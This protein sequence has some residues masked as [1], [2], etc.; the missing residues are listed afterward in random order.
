MPDR[1]DRRFQLILIKPSHY[2]A[3]GY[4]IQW[5]K[6]GM[7]SNSLAS[8]YALAQDAKDN[9]VLGPD[10]AIDIT[11]VDETNKAIHVD[12]LIA[13]LDEHDGFGL[14]G[15][16]GVQSNEYFRALDIARQFRNAGLPV[17]IG[18]FHVSGCIAMFPDILP[19]LQKALDM[20]ITLFAGEGEGR[21][22]DLLR[23]VAG[24][25]M[26]PV[27]NYMSD[28]PDLRGS[29]HPFLPKSFH[30]NVIGK[31]TS[32]DAGRGCPYQC[33]F[34]TIINVQGRVSRQRS[35]DDVEAIIRANWA[36]NVDRFFITDD[37]FARNKDWEPIFDRIIELRE[38]DGMDVR[39]MIQVDT[40][41]HKI[42]NF[43]EKAKRAGVTRVFIGLENINPENLI[44]AQKRQNKITD[45]R[46]MLLGWKKVGI[47]V[48]AGYILGFPADTEESIRRDIEIIKKELPIDALEFFCLTPLPGS[49]D[50]KAMVERGEWMD[51]D[52]N[53]Y[54]LEHVVSHH[55][56]MSQDEWRRAYYTAWKTYY[57]P[58]HMKTVMK[59]GRVTGIR[60]NSLKVTFLWFSSM[61]YVEGVHPLQGGLVRLKDRSVRRPGMPIEP[62]WR[63]YPKYAWQFLSKNARLAAIWLRISW[64]EWQVRRDPAGA[65]YT[66]RAM[67]NASE[68]DFDTMEIYT[69]TDEARTAVAHS[70]KIAM[71]KAKAR[72]LGK[73]LDP[74]K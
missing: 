43:M 67:T 20:G 34:C 47:I 55:P 65:S 37:N 5:L 58:Q 68:D 1:S 36:Q 41:C 3:D 13:L 27:Y 35:P 25:E 21:F 38:R 51:P 60:L 52:L 8:V 61:V 19:D 4:V 69:H 33:S 66:D 30:E 23:D 50:H 45:Y 72:L 42:P 49:A 54:D 63:F 74:V 18:G 71:T 44:A 17:A 53:K 16:V 46:E 62:A 6:S 64:I 2:D 73:R 15:I 56:K 40:L 39:F 26:K 10:V 11:A 29:I 70:R 24:G 31:V 9:H 7:P 57:T 48:F 32:F 28:L 14:A 22:G 59:R 12:K